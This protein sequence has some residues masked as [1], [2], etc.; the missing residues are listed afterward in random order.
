MTAARPEMEETPLH[1]GDFRPP[2]GLGFLASTLREAGHNVLIRDNYIND[3][4]IKKVIVEYKPDFIGFYV[5]TISFNK[6]LYALRIAKETSN[7]P[8]AVGGPHASLMP[9]SFPREVDHVVIGEAENII[10]NLVEGK[11]R[12][13]IIKGTRLSSKELNK[14]PWPDYE[15]FINESYN[16]KLEIF[17]VNAERVFSL[18]TSR[19]CNY[20][21]SFCG[22]VRYSGRKHRF[23]SARRIVQEIEKLKNIYSI[24]G[25]YFR[26]DNFTVRK[27]RLIDFCEL[28]KQ[29][30]LKIMWACESRAD[31][32]NRELLEMM[33]ES[34][35]R[36]LYIGVESGSQRILEL[37]KKGIKVETIEKFFEDC[38]EVGISTYAT[39][40]MGIPGE[41]E[42]DRKLTEE[43]IINIKPTFI[44]KFAYIGI[45]KSD[46]YD[47]LIDNKSFYYRDSSGIVF[48]NGYRELARRLYGEDDKRFIP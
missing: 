19:G 45:P 2:L 5:H 34:G 31:T 36:G 10:V 22:V 21:C 33:Y 25:V 3:R 14:L 46:I 43:L 40:C 38:R 15:D 44:D 7:V 48:P 6:F 20:L 30:N 23:I 35:C 9:D 12:K 41:T 24:D 18:N 16:W 42:E 26:E 39:F 4:D 17:N 13:R 27:K 28:L 11:Y 8:V 32:G 37:M 29:K 47:E 1:L